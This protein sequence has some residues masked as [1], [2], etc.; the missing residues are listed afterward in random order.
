[1]SNTTNEAQEES[2]E[3]SMFEALKNV[4]AS[5]EPNDKDTD[6]YKRCM[7][8]DKS[9]D[10]SLGTNICD[11]CY[12]KILDAVKSGKLEREFNKV[13]G[14]IYERRNHNAKYAFIPYGTTCYKC[15]ELLDVV[16]DYRMCSKCYNEMKGCG[17]TIKGQIIKGQITY[18]GMK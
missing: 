10:A 12:G 8:C 14:S 6:T 15:G 7:Q 11:E 16:N 4:I 9:I 18:R 2:W 13:Y 3:V 5:R 17:Q 1:M